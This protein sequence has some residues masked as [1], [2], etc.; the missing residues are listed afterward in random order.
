MADF[1]WFIW[2]F[3]FTFKQTLDNYIVV[4]L[5]SNEMYKKSHK[6]LLVLKA[7]LFGLTLLM[8][9]FLSA[10]LT[11]DFAGD[12]LEG[13]PPL[14]VTFTDSSSGNITYRKWIFGN[15]N[16]AAGNATTVGA[17][18]TSPG[19][20]TVTLIVSDGIDTVS[21]TKTAYIHVFNKPLAAF[22]ITSGSSPG[23]KPLQIGFGDLSVGNGS[24]I[25][26]WIWDFG[27]GTPPSGFQNPNH[28]YLAAGLF[29]VTLTVVDSLGCQSSTTI[30]NLISV[31]PQPHASFGTIGPHNACQ[32]PLTVNFKNNSTGNPPLTYQWT[33]AG[34]TYTTTAP[35]VTFNNTGTYNVSLVVTDAQGCSDTCYKANYIHIGSI[36]ALFAFP[37][38]V[39]PGVEYQFINNSLGGTSYAWDFGDGTSSSYFNPKHTYANP[40]TYVVTLTVS[41]GPGCSDT[42]TDTVVVENV[43]AL[44]TSTPHYAC[45]V[46]LTVN[47]TDLSTGNIVSWEWRFGDPTPLGPSIDTAQNPTHSFITPGWFDDTLIV[48]TAIGCRD[49]FII[50]DNEELFLINLDIEP[51]VKEGCGPLTVNFTNNSAPFDSIAS[52]FWDFADSSTSTQFAPTHTFVDTGIYQVTY[53]AVTTSGCTASISVT[54]AVGAPQNA[55]FVVDTLVACASDT[56]SLTNLSTDTSLITEYL[57]IF[58]DGAQS[59]LFE[60]DHQ[61]SDTG[62]MSVQLIV[63]HNGCPDTMTIDSA[64]YIYGPYLEIQYNLLCD[65]PDSVL[66]NPLVLGGTEF[67]WDFGDSSAIDTTVNPTHIFPGRGNY[68]VVFSAFDSTTGCSFTTN[69]T[70]FIRHVSAS[71]SASD[72][73]ICSGQQVNFNAGNSQDAILFSW[74]MLGSGFYLDD[75]YEQQIF[76]STGT[77]TVTLVV[78]D[79]N[80]CTDTATVD[81]NVFKPQVNFSVSPNFGCV[82]LTVQFTDLTNSDTNIVSWYW[83]FGDGNTSTLQNPQH[84]YNDPLGDTYSISLTVTDTF[85]CY[86]YF[87]MNPAVTTSQPPVDFYAY[88][89]HLCLGDTVRFFTNVPS[90]LTLQWDFGDST[91]SGSYLP[92]H[93]YASSGSY[94]IT[95]TVTDQYGCTNT[96]HLDDYVKVQ[97][98]PVATFT[99]NITDTT[100]Y[101]ADV[102]F[103]DTSQATNISQWIWNFGDDTNWVTVFGPNAWYVYTS[104]G[105]FDVTLIVQTSYGCRDTITKPHFIDIGGPSTALQVSPIPA[106]VGQPVRLSADGSA[107]DLHK[108]TWDFGDGTVINTTDDDSIQIHFYNNE[109]WVTAFILYS[110]SLNL[111][112]KVDSFRFFVDRVEARFSVTDTAGCAP[113]GISTYNNSYGA[114]KFLW[115]AGPGGQSTMIDAN[116]SFQQAGTYQVML[117]ATNDTT[118]CSDTAYQSIEVFP[119]PNIAVT[120]PTSI[121]QGD[122]IRLLATGGEQYVWT[123]SV[124]LNFDTVAAPFAF[125]DTTTEF[126]VVVTDSNNCSNT[127]KT[128][129]TVQMP[130]ELLNFPVDT[131][132]FIGQAYP[133]DVRLNMPV[134]FFWDPDYNLSCQCLDAEFS[135]TAKTT[136]VFT[137]SDTL[138]CFTFDTAFTIDVDYGYEFFAPNAFSPNGDGLNDIFNFVAYGMKELVFMKIYNRWGELVFETNDPNR[139]WDGYYRGQIAGHNQLFVYI[140]KIKRYND[141]ERTYRGS[142]LL[143]SK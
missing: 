18:Y 71:L 72:T 20:Y 89:V 115:D 94:D 67:T 90:G 32:P 65:N 17:V 59:S 7:A 23:C 107:A 19:N 132:V 79:V 63:Y 101:P 47:Y 83:D 98:Y 92:T 130:P 77:H 106:C 85:G 68:D 82:P 119:I 86:S 99:S 78:T 15:G 104:P 48:T 12:T 127:A 25:V 143:I 31:Y 57:W 51:D 10:Q 131:F 1:S 76:N 123:P 135:P 110:D 137:Y 66:F 128:T 73:V 54:I 124:Y 109:G 45:E 74:S 27:D 22:Y 38:T 141:E 50:P 111:C 8:P 62:Y 41:D 55:D 39:C 114:N 91:Q 4:Y 44:F 87:I 58:G 53:T 16:M 108:F 11:A 30:N 112:P 52:N 42:Y 29:D 113:K 24:S 88:P 36:Q 33:I 122:S 43:Q 100:C 34:N 70:L 97:D 3:I 60:P 134:L 5:V 126:T 121:C 140:I 80:G 136:Y 14:L 9:N 49:T 84:T 95:L 13:C 133:A 103:S 21:I 116:F 81:V 93:V 129:I 138:K 61:F 69:K 37:D 2:I 6:A 75:S 105:V 120:P 56:V 142:V 102:L 64:I 118:G 35:S 26:Q 46:P 139:G 125:P 117:V 96:M 28:T 40:G